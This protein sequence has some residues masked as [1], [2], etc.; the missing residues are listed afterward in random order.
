MDE[1]WYSK[2]M[3]S[4][5]N[6]HKIPR[7]FQFT[8]APIRHSPGFV[9]A[10]DCKVAGESLVDPVIPVIECLPS[11]SIS[12]C[13]SF[14]SFNTFMGLS[15]CIGFSWGHDIWPMIC[16]DKAAVTPNM[17]TPENE[18]GN[19]KPTNWRWISH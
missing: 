6:F 10:P 18:H 4:I 7:W 13:A 16:A 5:S 17:Y 12:S 19:K 11:V 1:N 2:C 15:T 3:I 9:V 8:K 14:C